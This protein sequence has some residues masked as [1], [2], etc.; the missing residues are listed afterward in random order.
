MGY[1]VRWAHESCIIA[2]KGK[3]QVL[4][5]STRSL[6]SA[7]VPRDENGEIIHSAKPDEFFEIVKSMY[8]GPRA[9]VFER[10]ARPGFDC[11]GDEM[12]YENDSRLLPGA[13]T[14]SDR[15]SSPEGSDVPSRR[16][17]R[18]V[19]AGVVAG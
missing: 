4:Q 7:P 10:K 15:I 1:I 6:F 14:R 13:D 11:Y 8:A 2:T 17:R 3:P 19:D 16:K 9:S 18:I 12:R 5:H